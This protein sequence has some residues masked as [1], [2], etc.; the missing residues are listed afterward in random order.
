MK[1]SVIYTLLSVKFS[2]ITPTS[3]AIIGYGCYYTSTEF[4]SVST[5]PTLC[6]ITTFSTMHPGS[7]YGSLVLEGSFCASVVDL[8]CQA[9]KC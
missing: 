5:S 4:S 6:L 9:S 3:L 7:M 1:V 2:D 8:F